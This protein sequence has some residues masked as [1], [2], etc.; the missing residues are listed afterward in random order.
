MVDGM[1]VAMK[2]EGEDGCID[3]GKVDGNGRRVR[4]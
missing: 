1:I 3:E 2:D 4:E